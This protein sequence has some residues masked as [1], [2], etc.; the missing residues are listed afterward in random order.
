MHRVAHRLGVGRHVLVHPGPATHERER[1][2]AH[3]LV[4]PDEPA[5]DGAVLH[6]HVTGHL[7]R[8]RDDHVVADRTVVCDVHV[9]HQEAALAHRRLPRGRRPPV[10]RAVLAQDGAIADLDPGLRPL[11]L[12]V[13]RVVADHGSVPDL[14]ARAELR[15]AL[16]HDVRCEHAAVT[17]RDPRTDDRVRADGHVVAEMR[18]GIDERGAVNHRSVTMA[19]ISASATTWPSTYPTPFMR[20]VLPR[21]CSISSSKRIWSPGTTGRR[22]FTLSSDMK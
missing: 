11:V 10:D 13:L 16:D 4:D 8:V 20:Q 22:N 15:V 5:D 6:R 18:R 17:Q 21:N 14:H 9:R 19:I 2:D 1:P 7:H 12:E 3:E